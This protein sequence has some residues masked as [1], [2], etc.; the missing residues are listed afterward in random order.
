M[1][2]RLAGVFLFWLAFIFAVETVS[3][4]DAESW[5]P[6]DI[7]LGAV[8]FLFV[9]AFSYS[10]WICLEISRKAGL[11]GLSDCWSAIILIPDD[12][13]EQIPAAR[14]LLHRICP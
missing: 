10:S 2:D 12:V 11:D 6:I 4:C 13:R 1:G 5:R 9:L 8:F 7:T 14:Y 3:I